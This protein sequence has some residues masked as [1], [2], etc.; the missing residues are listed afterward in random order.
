MTHDLSNNSE[1]PKLYL[2]QD[3]VHVQA[4]KEIANQGH[5]REAV[6]AKRGA[7]VTNI[8]SLTRAHKKTN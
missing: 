1:C 6:G 4:A 5:Q 7:G 3:N 2:T 8:S